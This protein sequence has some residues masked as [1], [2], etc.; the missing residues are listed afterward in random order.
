MTKRWIQRWTQ[1]FLLGVCAAALAVSATA[2]S[3]A[4]LQEKQ[5]KEREK[6]E[7]EKPTKKEIPVMSAQ[8]SAKKGKEVYDTYC[9]ICHHSKSDAKKIGPGLKGI[10]KRGKFADGKKVDDRSMREWVMKGGKDMPAFEES[11]T[12]AE[13]R[14]LIAYIR[15]L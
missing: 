2:D 6:K 7:P 13:L 8:P 12:A 10:Y 1:L 9:E 14:D 3:A 11:L 15:T 4:R 5:E